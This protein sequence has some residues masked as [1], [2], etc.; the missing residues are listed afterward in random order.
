MLPVLA[1]QDLVTVYVSI[2]VSVPVP[3]L[4]HVWVPYYEIEFPTNGQEK[5]HIL[6]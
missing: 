2:G 6:S 4:V 3:V 1:R 5:T